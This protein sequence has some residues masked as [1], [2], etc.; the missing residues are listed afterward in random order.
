MHEHNAR[1]KSRIARFFIFFMDSHFLWDSEEK[2]DHT[3]LQENVVVKV[4]TLERRLN[5]VVNFLQRKYPQQ[6]ILVD[7]DFHTGKKGQCAESY[8]LR[9]WDK[10]PVVYPKPT[11]GSIIRE[12][13][14][15]Q[16]RNNGSNN[17]VKIVGMDKS[18]RGVSRYPEA[19]PVKH[20]DES[21]EMRVQALEGLVVLLK[22]KIMSN[23]RRR[24][25]R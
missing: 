18:T 12:M 8:M 7:S 2:M 4:E 13:H 24:R 5:G 9:S 14:C 6:A 11:Y 25:L 23:I 20:R 17:S 22:G 15:R 21:L 1:H 16:A 3:A 19:F 10:P